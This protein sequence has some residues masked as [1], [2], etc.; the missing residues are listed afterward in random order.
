VKQYD[1][2]AICPK[3]CHDRVGTV[4]E[5]MFDRMK[6]TCIRCGY[7]W[8]ELPL[9]TTEDEHIERMLDLHRTWSGVKAP[10]EDKP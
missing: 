1:S 6:R 2:T 5:A 3:C 4:H 7:S 8:D 10:R 9:D